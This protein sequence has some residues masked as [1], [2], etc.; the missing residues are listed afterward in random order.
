[1]TERT[2]TNDNEPDSLP[3][4][5]PAEP[6]TAA[7]EP[8]APVPDHREVTYRAKVRK[9]LEAKW[10]RW[11]LGA[12]LIPVLGGIGVAIEH[13]VE[14]AAH[15]VIHGH[16]KSP[17]SGTRAVALAVTSQPDYSYGS[18]V[19][20]ASGVSS[21]LGYADLLA[22][23]SDTDA[24]NS[25]AGLLGT[26]SGS[27]V[28][29]L[30]VDLVLTGQDKTKVRVTNVQIQRVGP[31]MPALS[32]TYIPIPHQGAEAAYQFTANMDA[33]DPVLTRVPN[34]QTFPD[35][36]VQLADGEQLTLSINFDAVQY[37][38]RWVL[39]VTYLTGTRTHVIK[40]EAPNGQP[41]AVTGQA[42]AYKDVYASNFPRD[43]YHLTG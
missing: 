15:Q 2:A 7:D 5:E 9:W 13:D 8:V 40:V 30:H 1:M 33:P 38:C 43:G 28:G 17:S 26:Y 25:W 6:T 21:G 35:F 3:K 29:E 12:M 36:N 39:L 42:T 24:E 16:S 10:L 20:L 19:A 31:V 22:G 11:T 41:F 32:G 18:A 4:T 37:S 23:P 34:G 27:P 14:H